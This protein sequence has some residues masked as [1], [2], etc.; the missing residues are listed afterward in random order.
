MFL[1]PFW[2]QF[3]KQFLNT[4][5]D[6]VPYELHPFITFDAAGR[7]FICFPRLNMP[8]HTVDWLDYRFSPQYYNSGCRNKNF[9]VDRFWV[10]TIDGYAYLNK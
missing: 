10:L 6:V 4:S 2:H 1:A 7:R 8:G 5:I 3:H 9:W